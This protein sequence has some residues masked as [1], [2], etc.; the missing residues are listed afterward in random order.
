MKKNLKILFWSSIVCSSLFLGTSFL[1]ISCQK[2]YYK[3]GHFI[4]N[5]LN[6]KKDL[7]K[8]LSMSL[9][10]ILIEKKQLSPA[11]FDITINQVEETY[12][13]KNHEECERFI[14][15]LYNSIQKAKTLNTPIEPPFGGCGNGH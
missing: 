11:E 15:H 7:I 3:N 13:N 5:S 14:E 6:Q 4:P 10:K 2:G 9:C 1:T 8:K 12:K